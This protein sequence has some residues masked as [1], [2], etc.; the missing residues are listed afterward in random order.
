MMSW[1]TVGLFLEL[2][3]AQKLGQQ[4]FTH[5]IRASTTFP[6]E[7]LTEAGSSPCT[8]LPLSCYHLKWEVRSQTLD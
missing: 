8:R 6:E 4:I 5:Q 1:H 7:C 2:C 3:S